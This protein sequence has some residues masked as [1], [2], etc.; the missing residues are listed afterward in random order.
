MRKTPIPEVPVF[1]ESAPLRNPPARFGYRLS[2]L[3]I[4]P[5][6]ALLLAPVAVVL[7]LAALRRYRA[8][9][10]VE[11]RPQIV[12]GL[13]IATLAFVSNVAGAYCLAKGFGWLD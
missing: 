1:A 11:G 10:K 5:V 6:A 7:L 2:V 13:I 12:T 8:D 3:S 4:T 9:P